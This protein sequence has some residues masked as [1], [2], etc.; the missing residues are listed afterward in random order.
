MTD[1]AEIF[2]SN[3][4][5]FP[6]KRVVAFMDHGEY[7]SLGGWG[8]VVGTFDD[9]ET[10]KEACRRCQEVSPTLTRYHCIDLQN[11]AAA[12]GYWDYKPEGLVEAE[13]A[14]FLESNNVMAHAIDT[15]RDRSA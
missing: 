4:M 14:S 6:A 5:I 7:D 13:G 10:A 9:M 15:R 3:N 8:D 1:K 12:H 11:G 2:A